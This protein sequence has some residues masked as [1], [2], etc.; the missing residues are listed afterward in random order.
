MPKIIPISNGE[1]GSVVNL[2]LK[3]DTIVTIR[4]NGKVTQIVGRYVINPD[5]E[6]DV[7]LSIARFFLS[8]PNIELITSSQEI[9]DDDVVQIIRYPGLG[10]R[11]FVLAACYALL[12]Q[13]PNVQIYFD[14]IKENQG[15]VQWVPFIN[16]GLHPNPQHI[17][18]F[19]N[20]PAGGCDR[21]KAM[22]KRLGVD[23]NSFEFPINIPQHDPIVNLE[24]YIVFAP[25][26]S[27]RS[28]RS[29]IPQTI[30]YVLNYVDFPLVLVDA[31]EYPISMPSPH[32]N[33]S[34]Q[35]SL[36]ALWCLIN[37]AI[38][39]VAVDTGISWVGAALGKPV[40][41][42]FT[43]I[44]PEEL[45]M[46]CQTCWS[47]IPYCDCYPCGNVGFPPPCQKLPTECQLGYTGEIVTYK[48]K[49]FTS[50]IG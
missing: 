50:I 33:T 39:V 47:V 44:P 6:L 46:A 12:Q 19:D 2:L 9:Q 27:G 10:D 42:F 25:F 7:P 4:N 40:L 45:I 11:V 37:D 5:E 41:T 48:I 14:T 31:N 24:K 34:G 15:W 21:T 18:N 16:F 22:G 8:I 28:C 3:E 43:M 36:E 1:K 49:E 26:N 38:G 30:E 20:I 17:I 13:K 35:L 29:L 23:V 32:I